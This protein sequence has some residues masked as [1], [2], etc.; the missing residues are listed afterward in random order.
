VLGA[1]TVTA[2]GIIGRTTSDVTAAF[3]LCFRRQSCPVIRPQRR[4]DF[5]EQNAMNT[6]LLFSLMNSS[7]CRTIP[8]ARAARAGIPSIVL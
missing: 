4:D 6:L 5:Y 2:V 1:K 8:G 3:H 7:R